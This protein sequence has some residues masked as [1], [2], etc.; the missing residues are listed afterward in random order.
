M[1]RRRSVNLLLTAAAA[2]LAGACGQTIERDDIRLG[3]S[4]PL[5]ERRSPQ[6]TAALSGAGPPTSLRQRAAYLEQ[7]RTAKTP[8]ER[9]SLSEQHLKIMQARAAEHEAALP[10]GSPTVEY[11]VSRNTGQRRPAGMG[12]GPDEGMGPDAIGER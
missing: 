11:P 3:S 2:V 1:F 6:S 8:E 12:P 5:A 7:T 9:K 4:S 10:T